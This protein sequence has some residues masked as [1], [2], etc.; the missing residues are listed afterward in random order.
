MAAFV[1]KQMVG[2]KL[3]AVKGAVGG[4]GGDD[5]ND[6]EK[7]EE[8]ERERQ[9]AIREAEE[10]RKEKHRKMEEERE[11]MRQEIRDK[12]NIKKKE[13]IVEQAPQEEPNPLMRKK[14]TP[15]ELAAEAEQEDLDDFTNGEPSTGNRKLKNSIETQ[16]NEIKTQIE[17]KCSLQ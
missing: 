14:K 17:G 4:D 5:E 9:E 11:K 15:E 7:E 13:E 1:A 3:N 8:A 12:Y 10:R 2:N 16:V 6:K